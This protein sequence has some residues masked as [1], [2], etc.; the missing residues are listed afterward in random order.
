MKTRE[1]HPVFFFPKPKDMMPYFV[2][3]IKE[4]DECKHTSAYSGSVYK[5]LDCIIMKHYHM[6]GKEGEI[7]L[8]YTYNALMG[9]AKSW[10]MAKFYKYLSP[11]N[12][13]SNWEN[14]VFTIDV[15][16]NFIGWGKLTEDYED[17]DPDPY[18]TAGGYRSWKAT[19]GAI[20]HY[21]MNSDLSVTAKFPSNCMVDH[22]N[23]NFFG[24]STGG[25]HR[26]YEIGQRVEY[27]SVQLGR[28]FLDYDWK[29]PKFHAEVV[30][31]DMERAKALVIQYIPEFAFLFESGN[32][33]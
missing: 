5:I 33:L 9:C 13:W 22:Y 29:K 30:E 3:A 20:V 16:N 26:T 14:K 4:N 7:H 21:Y 6:D 10:D 2:E 17:S 11:T 15:S 31:F 24:V 25:G 28:E 8:E 19:K 32:N 23:N 18:E 12:R 1:L 27:R